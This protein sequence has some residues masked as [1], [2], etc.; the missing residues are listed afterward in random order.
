MST[1]FKT[2][3]MVRVLLPYDHTRTSHFRR[4]PLHSERSQDWL[5]A[6][7]NIGKTATIGRRQHLLLLAR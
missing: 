2:E 6:V 7:T 5:Y 3:A 4:L 1:F